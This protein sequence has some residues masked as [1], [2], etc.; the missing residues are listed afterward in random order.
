MEYREFKAKTVEEAITINS[1]KLNGVKYTGS[2]VIT[3]NAK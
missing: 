3:N 1:I 2:L